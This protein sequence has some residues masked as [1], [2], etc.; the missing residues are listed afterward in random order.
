M[1]PTILSDRSD[2]SVPAGWLDPTSGVFIKDTRPRFPT[3]FSAVQLLAS[4]GDYRNSGAKLAGIRA[5]PR[6]TLWPNPNCIYGRTNT[7]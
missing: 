6:Y 2:R 7:E 4:K 1:P 5:Q 3:P